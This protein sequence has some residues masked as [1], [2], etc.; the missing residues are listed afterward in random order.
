M[1]WDLASFSNI[2]CSLNNS[3]LG[4]SGSDDEWSQHEI[5]TDSICFLNAYYSEWFTGAC[6]FQE[7]DVMVFHQ[8]LITCSISDFFNCLTSNILFGL[9]ILYLECSVSLENMTPFFVK[10][11]LIAHYD[12]VYFKMAQNNQNESRYVLFSIWSNAKRPHHS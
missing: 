7:F 10:M 9:S 1:R 5:R 11:Q 8:N 6:Y 4:S 3:E 12:C 2:Q